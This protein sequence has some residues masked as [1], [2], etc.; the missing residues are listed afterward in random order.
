MEGDMD[1]EEENLGELSKEIQRKEKIFARKKNKQSKLRKSSRCQELA[2]QMETWKDRC[3][4]NIMERQ[5]NDIDDFRGRNHQ[6][7][8]RECM[9][10]TRMNSWKLRSKQEEEVSPTR[11]RRNKARNNVWLYLT[12]TI[13]CCI[14][15]EVY[16]IYFYFFQ[17]IYN[18]K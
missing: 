18:K 7:R 5:K 17:E 2:K 14:V 8:L 11:I 10:I 9:M 15:F 3:R 4:L 12:I 6:R 16:L 1:G 13:L